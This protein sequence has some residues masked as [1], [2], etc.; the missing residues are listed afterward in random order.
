MLANLKLYFYGILVLGLVATHFAVYE[1]GKHNQS[2]QDDA[3]AAR[4]AS[5]TFNAIQDAQ[6]KNEALKSTL[7]TEHANA[8][9]ALNILLNIPTPVV[10]VPTCSNT[11]S[12]I[13]PAS[14]G[15]VPS[16]VA[17]RAGNQ[18][19]DAFS[20]FE[21]QLESDTA[22]WSR[23]LNACFVVMKWANSLP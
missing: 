9:H 22:E 4:I 16:T 12:K 21:Q 15:S 11:G 3:K 6:K 17:E 14:G 5:L 13:N 10:R 7:E 19:Q 8:E 18:T 2:M 1:S 20:R 23:A